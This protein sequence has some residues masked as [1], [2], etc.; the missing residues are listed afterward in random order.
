[1]HVHG[2][3]GEPKYGVVSQM[4]L[5]GD[6]DA[7]GINIA[8]NWT[9]MVARTSDTARVGHWTSKLATG[10]QLDLTATAHA[11][12]ARYVYPPGSSAQHVLVDLAH[13]L[14]FGTDDPWSQGFV[15]GYVNIRTPNTTS[16]QMAE[17][18]PGYSG[19]AVY[20]KAWNRGGPWKIFFCGQFSSPFNTSTSGVFSYPYDPYQIKPTPKTVVQSLNQTHE[21]HGTTEGNAVGALF[22]WTN[23]TEIESRIGISFMSAE[24][25][26]SFIDDELPQNRTF[27]DVVNTAKDIWNG[28]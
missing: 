28:T 21:A 13:L 6:L 20:N 24:K 26:C 4:P 7:Q 16:S 19:Y 2:T 22:S 10:I 15:E 23:A 17:S 27:D 3:G 5:V 14:P 11:G 25:A 1:M 12:I 8:N 18:M 9:Y